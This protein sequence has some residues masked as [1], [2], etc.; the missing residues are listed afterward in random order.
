[1]DYFL[2]QIVT[3]LAVGGTYALIALG[4]VLYFGVLN[5]LNIA[6][7]QT[8]MLAPVLIIVLMKL[9][10]A[11]PVAVLLAIVG[12]FI[13]S[14][15]IYLVC[16]KPFTRVGREASYLAPFI[17]SFGVSMLVEN[18]ATAWLGSQPMPFPLRLGAELWRVGNIAVA[19]MQVISL[20]IT[21]VMVA[22]L[23]SAS[24]LASAIARKRPSPGSARTTKRRVPKR[25]RTRSGRSRIGLWR[26]SAALGWAQPGSG[27]AVSTVIGGGR[28]SVFET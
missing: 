25:R 7:A 8:L 14:Y 5:I 15:V 9:N 2:Q 26:C 27:R 6:H 4:F 28:R 17:A 22:S 1:M 24:S 19:P 23:A 16:M 11:W 3:G 10:Q 20:A 21:T 13:I 12:T 18:L